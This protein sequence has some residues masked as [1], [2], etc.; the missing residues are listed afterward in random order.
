MAAAST[1]SSSRCRREGR[2]G[3]LGELGLHVLEA[4]TA[5]LDSAREGHTVAIGSRLGQD[6]TQ[7]QVSERG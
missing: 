7:T 2:T 1:T 5:V 3:R 6:A 4:A